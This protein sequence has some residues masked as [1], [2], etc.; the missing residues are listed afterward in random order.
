VVLSRS[1]KRFPSYLHIPDLRGEKVSDFEGM[2]GREELRDCK[3]A[4]GTLLAHSQNFTSNVLYARSA[5]TT[6][7][8]IALRCSRSPAV[9][10][11][12]PAAMPFPV[13]GDCCLAFYLPGRSGRAVVFGRVADHDH[14]LPGL[15]AL[16][17]VMSTDTG[18]EIG[19]HGQLV[20]YC[21]EESRRL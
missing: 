5:T 13:H 21:V 17:P 7:E 10:P 20:V 1:Q 8:T 16:K 11:G 15:V 9:Q 2:R 14:V 18:L 4:S 19:A 3:R 6:N 12:T